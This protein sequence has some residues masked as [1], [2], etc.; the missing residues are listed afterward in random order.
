MKNSPLRFALGM[1]IAGLLLPGILHAQFLAIPQPGDIFKEFTRVI[2]LNGC[3]TC[4][5]DPATALAAAQL[6]LPNDVLNITIGDLAGAIRAELVIDENIGHVGTTNKKFRFNGNA[7]I[8][9]PELGAGNGIPA[10]HNG[11][12]YSQQFNPTMQIPLAHLIQGNNLFQGTSGPQTCYNFGWGLWAWY[13]VMVRVYYGPSKAHPTGSITSPASGATF[14]ENPTVT[15]STSADAVQVDF[16]GYYDGYDGDGDG[17]TQQ[18]HYYYHRAKPETAMLMKGHIGSDF[19]SPFSAVWNTDLVPNQAPGSVK[20]IARI[21]SSSGVWFVTNAVTGLSLQRTGNFVKMYRAYDMPERFWVRAGAGRSPKS[22]HF[23]IP[24]GDNLANATSVKFIVSTMDADHVAER[25]NYSMKVNNYLLPYF[26]ADHWYSLDAL[27]IPKSAILQGTNTFTVAST[28]VH[29]GIEILW[30]GPVLVIRYSGSPSNSAP[31]ITLH[32]VS[33][34]VNIGQTATF[35]V[36][37][38]GTAPLAYQWQKNN[39]NIAGATATS[40]TT[41][42]TVIGDNGATFRCVVTNNLGNATSNSATLTVTSGNLPPNVTGNPVDQ[43]VQV[44]ATASFN[45]TATGTSPLA[46]QWQKNNANIGGAIAAA[47]TTPATVKADSGARFRCIVSNAF[48]HDTSAAALL[49]VTTSAPSANLIANPGFEVGTSPWVFFT[50]GVGALASVTP[51]FEGLRSGRVSITTAGANVQ[52]YQSGRTLIAGRQY[53]LTFS[54]YS[55]T[56]HDLS[57]SVLK[58]ISPYTSYGLGGAAFNLTNAWQTFTRTFTASGFAGTVTDARLRFWLAPYDANGDIYFIDGVKLELLPVAGAEEY[59]LAG[60]PGLETPESMPTAFSLEANYP[61]PFNP[62]TTIAF[63]VP[64]DAAVRLSVY[65]MLGQEVAVLAEG[66][67]TAG[68]YSVV[69]EAKDNAGRQLSSGVYFY[70]M[71]ATGVSGKTYNAM[72][73]MVLMK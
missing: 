6:N 5:T 58:Q 3:N 19:A 66:N 17:V 51:G 60:A 54:A 29:H 25:A 36:G 20:L 28:T 31:S 72:Q 41:P 67:H 49:R 26:G 33:Q 45:V 14:G 61:N 59:T 1:A 42:A 32:P 62:S 10:G 44:G 55:N 22:T 69:W 46:Y 35:T 27:T 56:G 12:C 73:K 13:E 7:W 50:D 71:N 47:Y 2:P 24:S 18:Y 57:V 65:N 37:A 4:V 21:K 8:N 64:E 52:L 53:R 39:L 34:T 16:L 11:Q 43:T 40:Y 23:A 48:G 38:V 63:G 70:R 15:A 9:I 30:P 68:R